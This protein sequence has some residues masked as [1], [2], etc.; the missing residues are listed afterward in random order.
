MK[1]I[2]LDI[3]G[4]LNGYNLLNNII[5]KIVETLHIEKIY[6][7][8][9][10]NPFGIHKEKVK[11]LAKIVKKTNAKIVLSSSWRGFWKRPYYE[12]VDYQKL[13]VDLFNKYNI[14]VI[15]LTPFLPEKTRSEEI[16]SWIQSHKSEIESFVILDDES[17]ELK[18]FIGKELVKTSSID[19]S[20]IIKGIWKENTGLKNKHVRKAIKILNRKEEKIKRNKRKRLI[21]RIK[22]IIMRFLF[23]ILL[24]SL[25]MLTPPLLYAL[26]VYK[27]A[28]KGGIFLIGFAIGLLLPIF[29]LFSGVL[30]IINWWFDYLKEKEVM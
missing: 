5:W 19:D 9:R 3:D 17:F 12:M 8:W 10:R 13:L 16:D 2:F 14:S 28:Y 25:L 21:K 30:I 1:I 18:K 22:T 29:V 4:V 7:D 6:R 27:I 23:I 26:M 20:E 24:P 11:R 15:D